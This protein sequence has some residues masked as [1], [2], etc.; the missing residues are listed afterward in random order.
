M[1]EKKNTQL[2]NKKNAENDEK[3]KGETYGKSITQ[4]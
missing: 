3:K 2:D 4:G 1:A